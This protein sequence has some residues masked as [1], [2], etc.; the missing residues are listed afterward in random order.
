MKHYKTAGL[1]SIK[2]LIEL[3]EDLL[4]NYCYLLLCIFNTYKTIKQTSFKLHGKQEF[5]I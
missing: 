5:R 1:T 4:Q 3:N 2:D